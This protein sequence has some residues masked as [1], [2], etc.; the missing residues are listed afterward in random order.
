[1]FNIRKRKKKSKVIN[2]DDINKWLQ[3]EYDER[4]RLILKAMSITKL[5]KMYNN[6][7]KELK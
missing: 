7:Y 3:T 4:N 6:Y 5:R 2:K 1:M